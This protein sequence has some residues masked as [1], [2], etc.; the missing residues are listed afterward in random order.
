MRKQ[1]FGGIDSLLPRWLAK[2]PYLLAL[3]I[4]RGVLALG[5]GLKVWNRNSTK[6][7]SLVFGVSDLDLTILGNAGTSL[8][9]LRDILTAFKKCFIFLGETNYYDQND[10]FFILRRMNF[11]ELRRDPCLEAYSRQEKKPSVAE[12]FVFIQRMLFSDANSLRLTPELR[13]AKWRQHLREVGFLTEGQFITVKIVV[14]ILKDL[15]GNDSRINLSLDL[16]TTQFFKKDFD[17]YRAPLGEGYW[18]LAP[19][20]HLWFED[21]DER[22]LILNLTAFEKEIIKLQIN[23]E[24]WG[25]YT[26]RLHSQKNVHF[27]LE[28]LLKLLSLISSDEADLL[29]REVSSVFQHR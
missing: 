17:F 14:D 22:E 19:H 24:F 6:T 1:F 21:G 3:W 18:I 16:W 8:R 25:L 23:W 28:R 29:R 20:L 26:Q 4:I 11:Y 27:H 10:L 15:A 9:F 2:T 5:L 12:K 13:Q 7:N